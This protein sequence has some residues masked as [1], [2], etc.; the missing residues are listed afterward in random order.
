MSLMRALN[1]VYHRTL[2]ASQT[3]LES[4]I[5]SRIAV[6]VLPASAYQKFFRP[7]SLPH[8]F[9]SAL[10]SESRATSAFNAALNA[11]VFGGDLE[12]MK[13]VWSHAADVTYMG[14]F[15]GMQVGWDQVLR[16]WESQAA[17]KITGEI[18]DKDIHVKVGRDLA[19]TQNFEK[20][21]NTDAEGNT[22][23]VSIRA[24]NIF[25]KEDGKWKMISHHTDLIPELGK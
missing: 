16:N 6:I 2:T 23:D 25:R 8:D 4:P 20:G 3:A 7:R 11:G 17:K 19:V 14:P 9:T 10:T 24:T 15:G 5:S 21:K 13:K 18:K 12:P 22:Y 1:P